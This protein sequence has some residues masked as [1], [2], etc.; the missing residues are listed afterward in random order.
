MVHLLLLQQHQSIIMKKYLLILAALPLI[1]ADCN[2]ETEPVAP[3]V[4]FMP[5]TTN[6]TWTYDTKNVIT[7]A[8][9]SFTLKVIGKDSSIS[10]KTYS[11]L[12]NTAGGNEYYAKIGSDYYQYANFAAAN[13]KL[14][15]LYLKDNVN[16]GL[17]WD[18]TISITVPGLPTTL[19][20]TLTNK[21][22]EK[23]ISYTVGGKTYTNVIRVKSSIGPVTIPGV[24]IPITPVTDINSYYA[25]GVGR[26]YTRTKISITIPSVT[27]FNS[28]DEVTLKSYTIVP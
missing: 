22:E 25:A 4:S 28:D 19:T 24:P 9:G 20:G 5:T 12:S 21:I 2:K 8:S 15:L 11:V 10:G 27:P 23:G 26:I 13:Q 14:E 1:A 3:A 6:S 7:S 17:S 16:A 18:Q